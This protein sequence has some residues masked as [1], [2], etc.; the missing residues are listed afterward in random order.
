MSQYTDDRIMPLLSWWQTKML[1]MLRKKSIGLH[2]VLQ[3]CASILLARFFWEDRFHGLRFAPTHGKLLSPLR[4]F[5]WLFVRFRCLVLRYGKHC[6]VLRKS[7]GKL[8]IPYVFSFASKR[9][10]RLATG[11]V[12][13]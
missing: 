11:E 6:I 3:G 12:A 2:C 5:I 1:A 8:F 4:G 10:S 7:W 13:A 9:L